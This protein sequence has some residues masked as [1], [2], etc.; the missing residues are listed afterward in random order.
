MGNA[1]NTP[2]PETFPEGLSTQAQEHL[3]MRPALELSGKDK[4]AQKI[5]RDQN[6]TKK[7]ARSCNFAGFCLTG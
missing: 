7:D 1:L 2:V 4:V 3:S 5:C 6:A